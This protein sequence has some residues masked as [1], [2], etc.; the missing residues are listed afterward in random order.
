MVLP[1]GG[2]GVSSVLCDQAVKGTGP[3]CGPAPLGLTKLTLEEEHWC[4]RHPP[5]HLQQRHF[6][7]PKGQDCFKRTHTS[8]LKKRDVDGIYPSNRAGSVGS[9][10]LGFNPNPK[11]LRLHFFIY[12]AGI[13]LTS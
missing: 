4:P 12:R 7:G 13:V 9:M 5:A 8:V 6:V 10:R 11:F 2:V 1:R 3:S